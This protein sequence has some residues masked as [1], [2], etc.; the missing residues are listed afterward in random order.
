MQTRKATIKLKACSTVIAVILM[1][2]MVMTGCGGNGNDG[3]K[4]T[5]SASKAV[6]S[7]S[8]ADA[9]VSASDA[10]D[11]AGENTTSV[12]GENV[13]SVVDENDTSVS[14]TNET[15]I[16]E[17]SSSVTEERDPLLDIP[18]KSGDFK[19]EDC[20]KVGQYAGLALQRHVIEVTEQDVDD[21]IS[22]QMYPVEIDDENAEVQTGDTVNID[23]TGKIDGKEFDG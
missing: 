19:L 5:S 17:S 9:S 15:E 4:D 2:T 6:S 22:Y 7:S 18:V 16:T 8:S 10:E 21:Y 23:F 13:T 14:G 20:I 1:A 11:T 3:K 12:V